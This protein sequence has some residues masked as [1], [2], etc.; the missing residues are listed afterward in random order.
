MPAIRS[1]HLKRVQFEQEMA[2]KSATNMARII[3]Q[4]LSGMHE[5]EADA[6]S[7]QVPSEGERH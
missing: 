6:R 5:T 3:H 7:V 4:K 2:D 1:N